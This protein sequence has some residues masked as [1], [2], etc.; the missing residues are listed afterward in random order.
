MEGIPLLIYRAGRRVRRK[1]LPEVTIGSL[2]GFLFMLIGRQEIRYS[3]ADPYSVSVNNGQLY[4]D[5][6]GLEP[7]LH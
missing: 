7:C 2:A 6:R 5:T 1:N 3:E 4:L